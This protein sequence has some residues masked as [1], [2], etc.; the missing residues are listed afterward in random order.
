M[1]VFKVVGV[2][3]FM[4]SALISGLLLLM[5]KTTEIPELAER[6]FTTFPS[7]VEMTVL[8]SMLCVLTE[9]HDVLK[10]SPDRK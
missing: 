6:Y 8:S 4:F 2:F 1:W 3:V 7:G 5:S 10:A 9:I